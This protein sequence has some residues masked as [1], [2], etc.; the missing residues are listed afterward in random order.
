MGDGAADSV[1][2]T[3]PPLVPGVEENFLDAVCEM[4][5]AQPDSFGWR[6]NSVRKLCKARRQSLAQRGK[7]ALTVMRGLSSA[8]ARLRYLETGNAHEFARLHRQELA[9]KGRGALPPA[10]PTGQQRS[11]KYRVPAKVETGTTLAGSEV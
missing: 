10:K 3:V 5:E 4:G 2:E 1:R 8:A 9:Q 6:Q 7:V 11:R